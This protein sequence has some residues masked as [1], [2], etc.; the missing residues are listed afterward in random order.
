MMAIKRSFQ[1][2]GLRTEILGV[3]TLRSEFARVIQQLLD[4]ERVD[5]QYT[6]R[7]YGHVVEDYSGNDTPKYSWEGGELV[8]AVGVY[9]ADVHEV[10]RLTFTSL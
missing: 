9:S 10:S 2:I 5:V 7:Y 4:I 3:G 8:R 1:I 6:V